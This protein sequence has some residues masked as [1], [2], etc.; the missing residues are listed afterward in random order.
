M[1]RRGEPRTPNDCA[2]T[3]GEADT[4]YPHLQKFFQMFLFITFVS[5]ECTGRVRISSRSCSDCTAVSAHRPAR[6]RQTNSQHPHYYD[7]SLTVC[8]PIVA[9]GD[10]L[11]DLCSVLKG[12]GR[13]TRRRRDDGHFRNGLR[14]RSQ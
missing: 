8:S 12:A 5:T 14:Q 2:I 11:T 7:I 9:A 6:D 13:L 3:P 10:G 1:R 4:A